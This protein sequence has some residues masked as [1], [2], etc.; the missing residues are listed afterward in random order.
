MADTPTPGNTNTSPKNNPAASAEDA[1]RRAAETAE[2]TARAAEKVAEKTAEASQD[3][4]RANSEIMRRNIETA[5]DAV[6]AGLETGMKSVEGLTQTVS[7]AFGV[8]SPNTE[9]AEQ[10]AQN[11][12]AISQAS[13]ALARGA[14]EASRAWLDLIQQGVRTNLEALSDLTGCRS[15][16]DVVALQS[17]VVRQ[18]LQRAIDSG[19]TIARTSTQ[20]MEEANRA[21]QSAAQM[22]SAPPR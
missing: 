4:V 2:K 21:I 8:V 20:A 18:N 9:L 5:Q 15:M 11:V 16:Q 1:G 7:R 3:A 14:Q 17:R 22:G 12:R 19:Q 10:S 6:M 13:T